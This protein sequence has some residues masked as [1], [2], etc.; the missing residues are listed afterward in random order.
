MLQEVDAEATE[1]CDLSYIFPVRNNH[2]GYDASCAVNSPSVQE[3][4]VW[5]RAS[6]AT[7]VSVTD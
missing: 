5:I 6:R 7:F 3:K 4:V 1:Q 2:W